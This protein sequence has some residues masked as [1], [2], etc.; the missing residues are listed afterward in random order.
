MKLKRVILT[1]EI[2]MAANDDLG[3]GGLANAAQ[4]CSS[5]DW[6]GRTLSVKEKILKGRKACQDACDEHATGLE[7]FFPKEDEVDS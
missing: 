4:Q 7:F 1:Y 6:S 3:Q 5:G 2:L